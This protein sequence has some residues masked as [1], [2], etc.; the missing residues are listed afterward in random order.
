MTTLLAHIKIK[1]GKSEKWEAIMADMVEQTFATETGV[2]RYEYW[3]GQALTQTLFKDVFP[4]AGAATEQVEP[5]QRSHRSG[6]SLLRS[7]SPMLDLTQTFPS[8]L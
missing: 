7:P 1:P 2:R 4:D 3:K 5:Q 8:T 6:I